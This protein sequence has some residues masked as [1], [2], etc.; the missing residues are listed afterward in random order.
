[1]WVFCWCVAIESAIIWVDMAPWINILCFIRQLFLH[2]NYSAFDA[3]CLITLI[4]V[5]PR[6]QKTSHPCLTQK[7]DGSV[8]RDGLHIR[9][10]YGKGDSFHNFRIEMG[11]FHRFPDIDNLRVL[12]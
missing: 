10:E 1:M 11:F 6:S 12:R 4:S 9:T 2:L 8:R 5:L 3:F 7:V